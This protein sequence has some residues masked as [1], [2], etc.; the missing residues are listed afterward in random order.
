VIVLPDVLLPAEALARWRALDV[1]GSWGNPTARTLVWITRLRA[2]M[3]ASG[4][5]EARLLIAAGLCQV[6]HILACL[7]AQID[8]GWP[9]DGALSYDVTSDLLAVASLAPLDSLEQLSARLS[10]LEHPASEGFDEL[11]TELARRL[12]ACG[13]EREGEVVLAR[14]DW[15]LPLIQLLEEQRDVLTPAL[16]ERL[17]ERAARLVEVSH[18]PSVY[19][20]GLFARLAVIAYS[21]RWL[22]RARERLAELAP[23]QLEATP[24]Y[25]HPVEDVAWA[26]AELG[27]FDE[28]FASLAKLDLRDRWPAL[29]RLLPYA[30]DPG[31]RSAMIEE[32]IAAV[33]PL[34]LAWAWL[35]EAAPETTPRVLPRI[36]AIADEATRFDELAAAVRHLDHDRTEPI[37]AWML[38]HARTHALA[39]QR[40]WRIWS[41]T[42]DALHERGWVAQLDETDRRALIDELLA[43]PELDLWRE[44]APFVPDDRVVRVFEHAH[45]QLALADH[46]MDRERWIELAVALLDRAPSEQ[47]ER[48]RVLSAEALTLTRVEDTSLARL[49]AWPDQQQEI[50]CR[51]LRQHQRDFLPGQL[52]QPWLLRLG[53]VLPASVIAS[54]PAVSDRISTEVRAR[55]LERVPEFVIAVTNDE[56]ERIRCEALLDQLL[57]QPGWPT[58]ERMLWVFALLGRCRGEAAVV[59]ALA[60]LAV[61]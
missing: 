47:V 30:S 32:L 24:D 14:V 45:A 46:Y 21:P 6:E 13:R 12:F 28:A 17:C 2:R 58:H 38:A 23:E 27:E 18:L 1:P 3:L 59:E 16:R 44:A 19:H 61:E 51:R 55:Q 5:R 40:G 42:L 15:H 11:H 8:A 36:M 43:H 48:W 33:E 57:E 53:W 22:T 39:D 56:G 31:T 26:T 41:D 10:G 34:E 50:L 29:L 54:V 35:L 37:C 49:S 25:A 20:V 60:A 52:I 4:G 7:H 9:N